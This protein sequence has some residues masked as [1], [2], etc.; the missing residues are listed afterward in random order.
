MVGESHREP[1]LAHLAPLRRPR[2]GRLCDLEPPDEQVVEQSLRRR[3]EPVAVGEVPEQVGLIGAEIEVAAEQ[4]WRVAGP[5]GGVL[6]GLFN[7]LLAPVIFSSLIEYPLVMVLA[8][9]L[10]R[11]G[12]G[13]GGLGLGAGAPRAAGLVLLI[14][15]LALVLY[16]ES[17]TL[18]LD[19]SFLARVLEWSSAQVGERLD[20]IEYRFLVPDDPAIG[21]VNAQIREAARKE[22]ARAK[23]RFGDIRV[24]RELERGA[25]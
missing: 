8:C 12:R 14:A 19:F 5:L 24:V 16:S 23:A 10:V 11:A 7:A 6:G 1:V 9:V 20:P 25:N 4:Q 17:A 2:S 18:R 21:Y 13:D 22:I 15:T 3:A